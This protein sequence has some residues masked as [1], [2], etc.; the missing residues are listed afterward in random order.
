M[1]ISCILYVLTTLASG[2]LIKID[3]ETLVNYGGLIKSDNISEFYRLVTSIFLHGD[4]FHLAFNKQKVKFNDVKTWIQDNFEKDY[5]DL[6]D[7]T[8]KIFEKKYRNIC[9][10]ILGKDY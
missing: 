3:G 8:K 2:N 6:S 1:I 7:R 9:E 10:V 4:I 5:N